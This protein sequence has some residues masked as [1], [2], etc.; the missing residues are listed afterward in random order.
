M[1][2]IY[3][4]GGGGGDTT[5]LAFWA[6]Y[7]GQRKKERLVSFSCSPVEQQSESLSLCVAVTETKLR[8]HSSRA[9]TLAVERW[10][11]TSGGGGSKVV[12]SRWRSGGLRLRPTV[13][14]LR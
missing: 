11:K 12:R 2:N 5:L 10:R 4:F 7:P 14:Q 6:L 3:A 9:T 1:P 13:P 8:G